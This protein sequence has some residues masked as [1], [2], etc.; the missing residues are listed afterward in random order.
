MEEADSL[1]KSKKLE[2]PSLIEENDSSFINYK[3]TNPMDK[4]G[5]TPDY[6]SKS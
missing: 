2:S 5:F 3:M 6:S 4:S 1:F